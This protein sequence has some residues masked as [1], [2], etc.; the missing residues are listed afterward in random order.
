MVIKA[1]MAFISFLLL[2]VLIMTVDIF[3]EHAILY[4]ATFGLVVANVIFPSWFF[5]GMEK[6]KYMTYINIISRVSFT[7]FR[8][9][10]KFG[11]LKT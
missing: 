7:I 6:M 8:V 4:F 1:V 9:N 2:S 10:G 11:G 5:Q 3:K